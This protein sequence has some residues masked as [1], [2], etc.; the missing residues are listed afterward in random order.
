MNF[1]AIFARQFNYDQLN[2]E[3]DKRKPA[4]DRGAHECQRCGFCCL[5]APPHLN[6]EDLD[7]LAAHHKQTPSEFFSAYCVV[8]EGPDGIVL[9]LRREHQ[10]WLAG[11]WVPTIET[12]SLDTPCVFH[13]SGGCAV[14]DVRPEDC[15]LC[16]CWGNREPT[17]TGI[18]TKD[19]LKAL[20]WDGCQYDPED[21]W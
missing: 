4:G 2:R 5:R 11:N 9:F 21:E 19:D 7:R 1:T 3:R 18:W 12:W 17:Q 15:R 6:R 16:E 13:V 14:Y 10:G 8:S 20:G